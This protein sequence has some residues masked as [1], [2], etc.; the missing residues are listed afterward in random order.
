MLTLHE[1][2]PRS[3]PES[4][5]F[6]DLHGLFLFTEKM[7]FKND[8]QLFTANL[9]IIFFYSVSHH[10]LKKESFINYSLKDDPIILYICFAVLQKLFWGNNPVQFQIRYHHA[11]STSV[12]SQ[13]NIL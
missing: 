4:K 7:A 6:Q 13:Y 9:Y 1:A 10:F 2:K 12:D 11:F 3:G 8:S 5:K